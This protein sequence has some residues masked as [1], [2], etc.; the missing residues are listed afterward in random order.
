MDTTPAKITIDV[1]INAPV[2]K[3]WHYW[4]TL[5]HIVNWNARMEARDRSMG[6]GFVG[7][8]RSSPREF[9]RL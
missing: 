2:S 9:A 1:L 7:K 8:Y 4:V 6:F 5:E 3:V